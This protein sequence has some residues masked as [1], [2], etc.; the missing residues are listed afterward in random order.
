MGSLSTPVRVMAAAPEPARED[1]RDTLYWNP[2]V[3]TD[4]RGKTSVRF[5]LSDAVSSFR[6]QAE[7]LG[8]GTVGSGEQLISS[9]L[10]LALDIKFPESLMQGDRPLLPVMVSNDTGSP[11]TVALQADWGGLLTASEAINLNLP[12]DA[13]G[14]GALYVPLLVS[15]PMGKGEVRIAGSTSKHQDAFSRSI[16]VTPL[17]FP[18]EQAVSGVLAANATSSLALPSF[19]P[20]TLTAS[21]T[22]YPSALSTVLAGMEGMLRQPGGCFEQTSSSN[23]PNVMVLQYLKEAGSTSPELSARAETLLKDGYK[24]LTGYESKGGGYEWFGAYP[25]HE[26]LTAYG[27]LEFFDMKQ[28]FEGV[29]TAMMDRTASWLIGTR[30]NGKGGYLRNDRALDSFGRASEEVTDAYVTWSLVEAGYHA[31]L[32]PEL[33]AM[34]KLAQKTDDP[35]LLALASASLADQAEGKMA[36][37]KLLKMQAEDGSWPGANHSITRSGGKNLLIETTALGVLAGLSVGGAEEAVVK[38]LS[39]LQSSRD[40]GGGWGATQATVLSLRAITT[41]ARTHRAT[42]ASGSFTVKINGQ[43]AGKLAY[44]A[45]QEKPLVLTLPASM[46][47]NG[48]NALVLEHNGSRAMPFTVAVSYRTEG[49]LPS[50]HV[51]V[52]LE[53]SL[54]RTSLR[55]GETT[56]LLATLKN[57]T[58]AGQP[59]TLAR[60]GI[61]GGL[62]VQQWQLDAL[63]ESGA[64]AYY[65]TRPS[66][67]ALY[68]RALAPNAVQQVALDLVA[69]VPGSYSSP[70]S[71]AYLYYTDESKDWEEGVEVRIER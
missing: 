3:R 59:M 40:A 57:T 29:D 68:W 61:P 63:K 49:P 35:Y 43:A 2:R 14:R 17:G 16:S 64:I 70:A 6:V 8:G 15:A 69:T 36:L 20:G 34:V 50:S 58:G 62:S 32:Q 23:Y 37:E 22:L 39:F 52:D 48:S 47:Q 60:I 25:A 26:A 38:G 4:S 12:L 65:E 45:G 24:R 1:F 31:K 46:L 55:V 67:V 5:K 27:L 42:P 11:E 51:A 10:P 66:E 13:R 19:L 18:Q 7:G 41:Y 44:Q 30:R 21:I 54:E 28:V 53:T 56:R 33:Q 9:Q 71:S